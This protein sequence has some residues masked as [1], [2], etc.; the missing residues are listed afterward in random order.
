MKKI[1]NNNNNEIKSRDSTL[2]TTTTTKYIL[3]CMYSF[4]KITYSLTCT[5]ASLE[6]FLRVI[7]QTI[8]L[9]LPQLQL[10]LQFSHCAFLKSKVL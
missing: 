9:I 10:N 5:P 1:N 4:T 8:V 2:P 6:Q 3:D 7:S